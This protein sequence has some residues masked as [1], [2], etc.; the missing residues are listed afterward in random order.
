MYPLTDLDLARR[1]EGAEAAANIALVQARAGLEPEVGATHIRVEGASAMFDGPDSPLTQTFGL[2]LSGC[3]DAAE[4][5]ALEGFFLS[6]S[7]P[8]HHEVSPL[9]TPDV[10][11]QLGARGYLPMEV[12]TVLVRPTSLPVAGDGSV[13]VRTIRP[14]EGPLWS[15]IAGAGWASEAQGLAD[16]VDALGKVMVRAEGVHCFLAEIEGVP[17]ATGSLC[18]VGDVALLAGA[19]T[20]PSARCRGAQRTLL[21]ARLEFAA[22]RG[23]SLAMMVAHPGS[24]SQ[25]NAERQGF[26]TVYTRTKWRLRAPGSAAP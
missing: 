16:F 17:V 1:L 5:E 20:I 18:I 10:L 3:V 19:S 14:E 9:A 15:S 12:S 21:A 13:R 24:G 26:R 4:F 2:G 7:A 6:R 11:G 8:V 25:R 23:A 22:S